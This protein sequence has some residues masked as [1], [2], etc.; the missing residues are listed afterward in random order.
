MIIIYLCDLYMH[1]TLLRPSHW[2]QPLPNH[3][4][5]GVQPSSL[6]INLYSVHRI[7]HW[8][9][10]KRLTS[11]GNEPWGQLPSYRIYEK[12]CELCSP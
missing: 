4:T 6:I 5:I 2:A 10:F 11:W 7:E 3:S 1:F 9:Q 12:Y 8:Y